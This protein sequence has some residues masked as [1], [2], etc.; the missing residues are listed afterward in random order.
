MLVT[1]VTIFLKSRHNWSVAAKI[2]AQYLA[3]TTFLLPISNALE[4]R[5]S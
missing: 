1:A 5:Y 2:P 3:A 4:A